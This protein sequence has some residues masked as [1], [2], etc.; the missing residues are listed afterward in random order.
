M[1]DSYIHIR[2]NGELKAAA[3]DYAKNTGRSLAGLIDWLLRQELKKNGIAE[4]QEGREIMKTLK[5]KIERAIDKKAMKYGIMGTENCTVTL[6]LTDTEKEEFKN[7]DLDERYWWEIDENELTVTYTE[8]P[9]MK[10]VLTMTAAEFATLNDIEVDEIKSYSDA[11][12]G[13][14]DLNPDT[15]LTA[16]VDAGKIRV[17][18]SDNPWN[19]PVDVVCGPAENWTYEK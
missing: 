7:L 11:C 17:T 9:G 13:A 2:I 6:T 15:E 18:R 14:E 10:E 4:R 8:E 3:Q 5:E 19:E 16:V 1:K 12:T